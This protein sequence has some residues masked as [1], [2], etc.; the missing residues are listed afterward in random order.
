MEVLELLKVDFKRTFKLSVAKSMVN[1]NLKQ[2]LQDQSINFDSTVKLP[3]RLSYAKSNIKTL[4]LFSTFSEKGLV[5]MPQS[6][7]PR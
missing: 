7:L 4:M 5:T 6:N 1:K 2:V 3:P